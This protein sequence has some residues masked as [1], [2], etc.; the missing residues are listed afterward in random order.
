MDSLDIV[1][2]ICGKSG[3]SPWIL[4]TKSREPIQTGLCPW[5]QW[6]CPLNLPGQCPWPPWTMSM[7]SVESVDNSTDTLDKV[8]A[9]WTMS[10][11]S[12]G[13]LQD[14][15]W[16]QWTIS[17]D[18]VQSTRSNTPAGQCPWEMSTES[19]DFLQTGHVSCVSVISRN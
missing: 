2:G 12:M 4:W 14:I 10:T 8:Q 18:I 17:M 1:H 3:Q 9:D 15:P 16:T 7:D 19:M 13:S 5:T 11:E 6:I